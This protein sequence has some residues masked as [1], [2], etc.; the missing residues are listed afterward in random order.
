MRP[1]ANG[2]SERERERTKNKPPFLS[3]LLRLFAA[4][5]ATESQRN[6]MGFL[7]LHKSQLGQTVQ[8]SFFWWTKNGWPQKQCWYI[9]MLF[10]N[11][12]RRNNYGTTGG[13]WSLTF[14]S[15]LPLRTQKFFTRTLEMSRNALLHRCDRGDTF[16]LWQLW[17]LSC[18]SMLP[19]PVGGGSNWGFWGSI[20]LGF[21]GNTPKNGNLHFNRKNWWSDGSVPVGWFKDCHVINVH[22]LKPM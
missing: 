2:E 14:F 12:K 18:S 11:P 19:A 3:F 22:P 16:C 20:D 5:Y 8:T 7:L 10:P 21:T 6:I 15:S 4:G 13:C 9:F 1:T 17:V